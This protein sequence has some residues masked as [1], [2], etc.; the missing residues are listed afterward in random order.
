MADERI[1]WIDRCLGARIVPEGLRSAGVEV[2]TY[3]ELYPNDPAVADTEWIPEV[4]ARGWVILTKDEN[5]SRNPVEVAALRQAK[6]IYVALAAKDMT[7]PDQVA[8]LLK[9][10][11]TI[12]GVVS[13]RKPPVIAKVTRTDVRWH[14]G[15][16]W[17]VVKSKPP[18]A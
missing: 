2:R 9:H 13:T 11:R 16:E 4:T 10:W 8:C 18:R 5:I 1:W 12:V 17:R 14:D 3:A 15:K 7:A 6:A